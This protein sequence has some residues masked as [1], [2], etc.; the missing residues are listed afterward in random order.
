MIYR[1]EQAQTVGSV[2]VQA[3]MDD[4]FLASDVTSQNFQIAEL[5][6]TDADLSLPGMK[7]KA[8]HITELQSAVNILRAAY[9]LEAVNFSSVLAGSTKIGN[10]AV[11]TELQQGLQ[12]VMERI[13]GWDDGKF[14]FSISWISPAASGD[15]VDRLKLRQAI[16]QLRAA[17]AEV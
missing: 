16:E 11:I 4:A 15:G 2:T 9:G 13:N 12:E 17:V 1:P 14:G 8:V 6:F 7:I 5:S 3:K 10:L